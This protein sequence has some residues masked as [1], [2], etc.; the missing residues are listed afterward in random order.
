MIQEMEIIKTLI[1]TNEHIGLLSFVAKPMICHEI[2]S[3]LYKIDSNNIKEIF[4]EE[5]SL[6]NALN[7]YRS[8]LTTNRELTELDHKILKIF[9]FELD[10]ILE[11]KKL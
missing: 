9:M 3:N 10:S 8:M 7:F 6:E 11:N 2:N 1:F 4:N 5:L